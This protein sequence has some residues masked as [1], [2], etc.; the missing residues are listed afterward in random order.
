MNHVRS[1][2]LVVLLLH[3]LIAQ[4]QTC[5]NSVIHTTP[6]SR[7]VI[8]GEEVRDLQTGFIWQRCSLGQ[9]GSA[10]AGTPYRYTWQDALQAGETAR[11]TTGKAWRLPNIKELDSIVENGCYEPSINSEI[12]PNTVSGGYW[13]ASKVPVQ[14]EAWYMTFSLGYPWTTGT[15]WAPL[16]PPILYVRLVRDGE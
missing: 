3:P 8:N 15:V 16:N 6:N 4:A 12:F 13:S 7:F 14:A 11:Q 2:G 1:L 5:N 10:C 9:T